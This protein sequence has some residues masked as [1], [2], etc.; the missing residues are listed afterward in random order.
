MP[1]MNEKNGAIKGR[2]PLSNQAMPSF[3]SNDVR[4]AAVWV[5]NPK[6]VPMKSMPSLTGPVTDGGLKGLSL[7]SDIERLN[8]VVV[9]GDVWEKAAPYVLSDGKIE[10]SGYG[11]SDFTCRGAAAMVYG[12]G[13]L[14]IRNME[15]TTKD[16][17]RCATLATDNGTLRVYDSKLTT[18]GGELPPD[19][20]PV[21]GPG[22]MEPPWP[23]GLG[24][25]CRTHLSMNGSR[26]YF[27]NCDV[28]A[29]AWAAFSTDSSGGCLYLE[30]NDS[31]VTV[32]G[33]GYG[34]YADNGCYTAFNRCSFDIGNMLAIQDGN[35]SITLTDCDAK[36]AKNGVVSHGGL[37][38]YVDTGIVEV[39]GGTI[40]A[41]ESVFLAKSTNIDVYVTGA[42]LCA[43][44]GGVLKS[45]CNDDPI[46]YENATKGDSY[47]GVQATFEAMDIE[48]DI[49]HEDTDRRM[50]L[51]LV[52]AKLT[53]AVTGGPT[54]ALYGDSAWTA[55]A[56]SEV[57]LKG[58]ESAENI[59]AA[60]GVVIIA[61]AGEG[62]TLSGEYKLKSGGTLIVA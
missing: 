3:A 55:T 36:C 38:E 44:N 51:S 13:E 14:E 54:L 47:Y 31:R 46:Y 56:S 4:E 10:L 60:A 61:K 53:G 49:L 16:A 52:D 58:T 25:N 48:G 11:C 15:I 59:D 19:Y 62:C 39:H 33:N 34:V 22:M 45:M 41:E 28:F 35:S 30:V 8:G 24:G 20:E 5:E 23:L 12:G 9:T 57:V 43:K 27:Y 40:T 21:I 17:T 18:H 26:S 1:N 7:K 29:E 37:P 32:P 42:K 2:N 50:N 6:Y